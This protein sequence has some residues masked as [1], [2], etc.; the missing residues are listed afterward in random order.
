MKES[1][2]IDELALRWAVSPRTIYRLIES[3]AL[4]AFRVGTSWRINRDELL[5]YEERQAEAQ[6]V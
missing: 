5:R 6:K 3:R 2:R 1:Y 4:K